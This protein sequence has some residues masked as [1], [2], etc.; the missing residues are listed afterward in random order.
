[1]SSGSPQGVASLGAHPPS[2]PWIKEEMARRSLGRMVGRGVL[3]D[4]AGGRPAQFGQ[5]QF[6][7]AQFGQAVR[8]GSSGRHSLGRHSLGRHSSGKQGL[9]GTG[10]AHRPATLDERRI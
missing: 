6:G 10:W 1:M 2:A 7:Q 3:R 4:A 5:A 9:A 8:A